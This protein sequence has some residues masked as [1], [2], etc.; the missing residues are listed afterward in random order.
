MKGESGNGLAE[1]AKNAACEKEWEM[2]SMELGK[3]FAGLR[4]NGEIALVSFWPVGFPTL[5]SSVKA[6][7]LLEK[8]SDVV[9]LGIPFTDP[10]ADGPVIQAASQ[11][12]I[13]QGV[14]PSSALNAIQKMRLEKPSMI[15]TY[16][17]VIFK[18]GLEKFASRAKAAGVQAVLAADLPIEES[19]AFEK[20]CAEKGVKTVFTIAPNTGGERIAKIASHTTGFLYLMAHYGVTG[21]K[22]SLQSLT[23]DAVKRAKKAAPDVPVCVGFGISRRQ[24]AEALRKAGADGA[25]VG[26][27]FI[28]PA[29]EEKKESAWLS[30]IERL[31][32]ELKEGTR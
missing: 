24:H 5:S 28:K 4:E 21:A 6:V 13:E 11:K 16:Y 8:Y 14:T 27:A 25:I 19:A 18:M 30:K 1:E 10:I 7:K 29:L 15:L 12:A 31:A 26:S 3:T 32:K 23:V 22:D 20:A 2:R 9:E 17:N